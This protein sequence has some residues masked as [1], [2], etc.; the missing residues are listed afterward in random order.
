MYERYLVNLFRALEH[1]PDERHLANVVRLL[2]PA[3]L[4]M[5]ARNLPDETA[6]QEIGGYLSRLTRDQVGHLS[7]LQDRLALLVEGGQGDWLAPGEGPEEELDLLEAMHGAAASSSAS[8]PRATA[9]PPGCSA[10]WWSR[11]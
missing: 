8:T 10:T 7:G 4:A 1:K 5:E 3:A 9:P 6:A 11:T 2:D